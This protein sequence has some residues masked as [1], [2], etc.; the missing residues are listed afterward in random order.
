MFTNNILPQ[1]DIHLTRDIT[2][3]FAINMPPHR[4]SFQDNETTILT[5][6]FNDE[7]NPDLLIFKSISSYMCHK[8]C[9]N[10]LKI[11]SAIETLENDINLENIA[12]NG[13]KN[14]DLHTIKPNSSTKPQDRNINLY[15]SSCNFVSKEET[16]LMVHSKMIHHDPN[17]FKCTSC[18]DEYP[19]YVQLG[20]HLEEHLESNNKITCRRCS[21]SITIEEIMLHLNLCKKYLPYECQQCSKC[22]AINETR[23]NHENGHNKMCD[24]CNICFFLLEDYENHLKDVH[25][26]NKAFRMDMVNLI[27][28]DSEG[29]S[30]DATTNSE[31]LIIVDFEDDIEHHGDRTQNKENQHIPNNAIKC[32]NYKIQR[33]G[34]ICLYCPEIL[35]TI[36]SLE[37]HC[38]KVHNQGLIYECFTCNKRFSSII[39]RRLH[40]RQN[41]SGSIIVCKYCKESLTNE[42]KANM[43]ILNCTARLK[44]SYEC[45]TCNDQFKTTNER[46]HH[47]LL[48]HES[49]SQVFCKICKKYICEKEINTHVLDCVQT[50][51]FNQKYC[52]E[53]DEIISVIDS[54]NDFDDDLLKP[55]HSDY[56]DICNDIETFEGTT[57]T[58]NESLYYSIRDDVQSKQRSPK[59]CSYCPTQFDTIFGLISHTKKVHNTL[60]IHECYSCDKIFHCVSDRQIHMR[61]VHGVTKK[62]NI[63]CKYCQMISL[64]SNMII[65]Y[66]QCKREYWLKT[67]GLNENV[68]ASSNDD[69]DNTHNVTHKDTS[70]DSNE[71]TDD[72]M[73]EI[74]NQSQNTE[75]DSEILN[76]PS[77]FSSSL[78]QLYSTYDL[79]VCKVVL[80][81]VFKCSEM[82]YDETSEICESNHNDESNENEDEEDTED[83]EIL[84][85]S[86]ENKSE[87]MIKVSFKSTKLNESQNN[88]GR[89]ILIHQQI[90]LMPEPNGDNK[91]TSDDMV[92][93]D[94]GDDDAIDI[95]DTGFDPMIEESLQTNTVPSKV[96]DDNVAIKEECSATELESPKIDRIILNTPNKIEPT[97]SNVKIQCPCCN[98]KFTNDENLVKHRLMVH[99][100]VLYKN[101]SCNL[102]FKQFSTEYDKINHKCMN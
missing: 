8:E 86:E 46:K 48:I 99:R 6:K 19:T 4:K 17:P 74:V 68:C 28:R 73:T 41:H 72:E 87:S 25:I 84:N 5:H 37:N 24:Y 11:F 59:W 36:R 16:D 1:K 66:F 40:L 89:H 102:C 44:I 75:P 85:S 70:S 83:E 30:S 20:K 92:V 81:D 47:L 88:D 77:D 12:I 95:D 23:L 55:L 18:D 51:S 32:K 57:S 54:E 50:S 64:E 14:T 80:K 52:E 21:N 79:T 100:N 94:F 9:D 63:M 33:D 26:M 29:G 31:P 27:S 10:C 67:G 90:I 96:I 97:S 53:Q 34:M 65:H 62:G 13:I 15:C 98:R 101:H 45:F 56:E 49:Y 71:V 61:K 82:D 60:L 43:H 91:E 3:E 58:P 42:I 2:K 76:Q 22:F 38:S 93:D 39:D 69:V 78:S 35:P 7:D